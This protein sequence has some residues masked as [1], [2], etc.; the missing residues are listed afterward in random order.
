MIL[1]KNLDI[2]KLVNHALK[3]QEAILSSTGA[4]V[5]NTSPYTGR[6][7]KDKFIVD[8]KKNH[9][10]INWGSINFPISEKYFDQLHKKISTYLSKKKEIYITDALA[11]A[12]PK[13]QLK[14]RVIS[15]FAYQSLFASHLLRQLSSEELK[16]FKPELTIL[17]APGC[18]ANPKIDGTNSE[19]FVILN[20][21][22]MIVLIGGTKYT[23]EIKKSIFTVMNFLLPQKKVFPMHCSANIGR[24]KESALFFG[25]SGTGKT[26]LSA[27]S[28]RMLIGDDEHGWSENGIFNFEG[29]CYA[30]CIDLKKESEPQIWKAIRHGALIE[31]VILDKNKSIDFRNKTITEN[32]RVAYPLHFIENTHLLGVGPHP[33]YVIFLTADAFGVLPP[34]AKL[35]NKSAMYH[36]LSGYTAKLAGTE[37]GVVKPKA[38]FSTCFGAPFMPRSPNTYSKLLGYYLKKY[39]A[40]TYL[41]NT[42]WIGGPYGSG[43]RISIQDT[44]KIISTILSGKM[45]EAEYNFNSLF[46]LWIPN[47]ILGVNKE[48][49]KPRNL[50]KNKSN[51]DQKAQE[52]AKLFVENFKKFNNVPEEVRKAGPKLI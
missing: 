24:N 47:E 7:P 44:R 14:T 28:N 31:N 39:Q 46:N 40:H 41:V 12:D 33:K 30:K 52:L 22:K 25:L 11:G 15:E 48:I 5:I 43:H 35:D 6:S 20:L 49:L 36:F 1:H 34:I 21:E 3:K 9:K 26:T 37:R 45:E 27:D 18:H 10:Q 19:A 42:G 17:C 2:N 4:I 23:G 50:W 29:G 38:T 13:Y 16:K 32:T 8:T 51:Y